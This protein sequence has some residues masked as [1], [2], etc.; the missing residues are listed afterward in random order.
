M[1]RENFAIGGALAASQDMTLLIRQ[2]LTLLTHVDGMH[3]IN[4]A[5]EHGPSLGGRGGRLSSHGQAGAMEGMLGVDGCSGSSNAAMPQG[6]RPHDVLV[7]EE[8]QAGS[9]VHGCLLL[10]QVHRA[11]LS[12][13]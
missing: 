8:V 11:L 2:R 4:S 1:P 3:R 6:A 9:D 10:A 5:G 12:S 7:G 13:Q